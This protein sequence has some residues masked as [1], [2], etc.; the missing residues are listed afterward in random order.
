MTKDAPVPRRRPIVVWYRVSGSDTVESMVL[1]HL[2]KWPGRNSNVPDGGLVIRDKD[3]QWMPAAEAFFTKRQCQK[4]HGLI[5]H[6]G[7]KNRK[8]TAKVLDRQI[9]EC[10]SLANRLS[11]L[12]DTLRLDVV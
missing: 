4:Y 11:N 8:A 3:G 9:A 5:N 1:D 7:K 10:L 2:E 12:R 6:A